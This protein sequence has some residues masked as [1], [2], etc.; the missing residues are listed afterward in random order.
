MA[1]LDHIRAC[2]AYSLADFVPF[3]VGTA[4]VGW[5]RRPFSLELMRFGTLFHVFEDLVHLEPDLRTPAD[6]TAAVA[7]ALAALAEDG[8]T[9]RLR[10]EMYPVI[11]R[12][13]AEPLF[14]MDRG[15][16]TAFGIANRGFHLN[17]LVGAGDAT[18]MWIARRALDKTTY[19][20]KLDNMVAGGHPAG[21][22]PLQNLLKECAEEAGLPEALARRARPVSMVSYTMEVPEGLRR[23]AFWAY[24]LDVPASFVPEPV[25]GEVDSFTLL[26]V[27]AV[28]GLVEGSDDFQYNCNLVII[29]WLMRSGRI[30]AEHPDFHEIAVGLHQPWP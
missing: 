6:R 24:D 3:H 22:T 26:P 10:G 5:I 20:G 7:D 16:V 8:L 21:L 4:R 29:D 30:D 27:D 11:E 13:G 15:A 9:E 14:D 19:P 23:H 28:A 25:D 18:R 12:L 2:N 1:F 17:G